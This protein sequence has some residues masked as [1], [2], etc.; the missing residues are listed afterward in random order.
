MKNG[1]ITIKE[2]TKIEGSAGLEVTVTNDQVS[3]VKVIYHDFRR[4]YPDTVHGKEPSIAPLV[5]SRICGTCS[6]SHL[7]CS[8]QAIEKSQGIKI[9]EQTRVLRR[10]VYDALIIRD[11]PLHLYFFALPDMLGVDSIFDIPDDPNDFGYVLLHDSFAMKQLGTD[12]CNAIAGAIMH[13]PAPVIG[14][15]DPLPDPSTFPKFVERLEAIRPLVIR[16]VKAFF[17][18]K[19]DFHRDYK[20]LALRGEHGFDYLEGQLV[21]HDGTKHPQ[22]D[23]F[24]K[25]ASRYTRDFSQTEGYRLNDLQREFTLGSLA[26]L[27]HNMDQLHPRTKADLKDYL[28]FFPSDNIFDNNLAQMI[29]TLQ[30]VD[31]AIDTLKNLKIKDEKPVAYKAHKGHGECIVEAPRGILYHMVD[32]GDDGLI[33]DYWVTAPSAP[34]QMSM[35][36]DMKK[37]F[38]EN[39]SKMSE[40]Q[41]KKEA[42]KIIRAYDPCITCSTNFLKVKYIKK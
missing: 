26:R 29:E 14:G 13:V 5:M 8:T 16:G 31:Q 42:E 7:L 2:F 15:F 12:L 22:E 36:A 34:N 9:S 40:D 28:G 38:T 6:I 30:S 33:K 39:Y 4:F 1:T 18:W 17:D 11:H 20:F 37:F 41:L 35:E 10:L 21:S 23:Y 3:D 19:V 25:V 27:N 32:V 24:S